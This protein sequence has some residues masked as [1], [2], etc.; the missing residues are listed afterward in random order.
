MDPVGWCRRRRLPALLRFAG[1]VTD[2]NV[3][4]ATL[5]GVVASFD[6]DADPFLGPAT[7]LAD[8][9]GEDL[10]IRGCGPVQVG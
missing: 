9:R 8:Q 1:K 3:G 2:V 5:L 10:G 4:S 7:F 6:G